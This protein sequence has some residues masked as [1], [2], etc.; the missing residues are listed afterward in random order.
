MATAILLSAAL[1]APIACHH[2][3][4]NTSGE[5]APETQEP[6]TL[7]VKNQGFLDMTIYV[8]SSG[9]QRIR[10]GL[11]T[12]NST[13]S[14]V[15]PRSIVNGGATPLRFIA[16]PVGGPGPSVSDELTVSPGDQAELTIPPA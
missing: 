2:R 3:G 7:K 5:E 1:A 4:E 12:G 14:F 6:T 8:V 16:N 11:A 15:I 13:T 9:G 10:L